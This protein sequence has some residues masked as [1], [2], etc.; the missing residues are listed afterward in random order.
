MIFA[1]SLPGGTEWLFIIAAFLFIITV[2]VM[3]IVYYSKYKQV[4][5]ELEKISGERDDLLRRLLDKVG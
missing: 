4:K 2:P 3:A 5:R 1:L